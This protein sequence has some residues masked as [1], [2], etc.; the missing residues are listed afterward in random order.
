VQSRVVRLVVLQL[1][2]WVV[3]HINRQGPAA[4]NQGMSG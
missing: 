2:T 3:V 1:Q 4:A